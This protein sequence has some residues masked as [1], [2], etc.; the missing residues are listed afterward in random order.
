MVPAGGKGGGVRVG[1]RVGGG[2]DPTPI[3][4]MCDVNS[5]NAKWSLGRFEV[6][7]WNYGVFN[8]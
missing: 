6:K 2:A 3:S 1:F 5:V 4:E 8:R 7:I